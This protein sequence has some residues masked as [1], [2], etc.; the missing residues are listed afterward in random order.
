MF[1]EVTYTYKVITGL[2]LINFTVV[3]RAFYQ[4]SLTKQLY[5]AHKEQNL[6][7]SSLSSGLNAMM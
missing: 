7:K 1:R 5:P 6:H 2:F 4:S 3:L